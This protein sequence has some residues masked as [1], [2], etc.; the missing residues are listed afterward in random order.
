M[1]PFLY[2]FLSFIPTGIGTI[3]GI[4]EIIKKDSKIKPVI[5]LC[6]NAGHLI[7]FFIILITILFHNYKEYGFESTENK[8]SEGVVSTKLTGKERYHTF[9][10]IKSSPYELFISFSSDTFI[11]GTIHIS[12]LKLVNTKTKMIVFGPDNIIEKSFQRSKYVNEYSKY[13]YNTYYIFENIEL[14]YEE[15]VLRMKFSLTQGDKTTEYKAE[16]HFEKNYREFI[17]LKSV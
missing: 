4:F 1:A 5:G 10:A 17:R 9:T 2:C 12:E 16:I 13:E 15:M 7:A 11:E 8:F 6:L 14:E 3:V